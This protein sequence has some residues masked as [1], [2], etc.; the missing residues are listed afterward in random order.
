MPSNGRRTKR[1]SGRGTFAAI[2]I[3]V[4]ALIGAASGAA[5]NA[6]QE[7]PLLAEEAFK[8]V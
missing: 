1:W 2:G 7:K 3:A 4:V 6:S 8:N 5:Q